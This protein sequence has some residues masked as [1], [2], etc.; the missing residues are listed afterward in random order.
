[1][2]GLASAV[3]TRTNSGKSSRE[4]F[5]YLPHLCA[6]R[7]YSALARFLLPSFITGGMAVVLFCLLKRART[8]LSIKLERV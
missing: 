4:G 8:R 5:I 3:S 2:T 1:M 6:H 7:D